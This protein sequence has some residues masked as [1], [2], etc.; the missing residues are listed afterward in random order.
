M[1][2]SF[3]VHYNHDSPLDLGSTSAEAQGGVQEEESHLNRIRILYGM[4]KGHLS[5]YDAHLLDC[6]LQE[7]RDCVFFLLLDPQHRAPCLVQSGCNYF[8]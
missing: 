7:N 3:W 2:P 6:Q 8:C 1:G 5:A 4:K